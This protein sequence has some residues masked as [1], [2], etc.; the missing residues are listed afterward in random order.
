MKA[1]NKLLAAL[2]IGLLLAVL[3][4]NLFVQAVYQR[5]RITDPAKEWVR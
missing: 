2:L 1:S 3:V 5:G 4:N